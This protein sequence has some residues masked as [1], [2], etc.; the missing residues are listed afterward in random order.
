[1]TVEPA[2]TVPVAVTL[3]SFDKLMGLVTVAM[4]TVGAP[5][6]FFVA[7]AVAVDVCESSVAVAVKVIVPS[8][9]ALT[10]IPLTLQ[11][12]PLTVAV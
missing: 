10:L 8:A 2:V 5:A 6:V 4:A 3:V 7:V 12:V 1:M 11:V 9:S